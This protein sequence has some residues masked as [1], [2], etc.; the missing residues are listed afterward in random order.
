MDCGALRKNQS[1]SPL[2]LLGASIHKQCH[3]SDAWI[4][5][6]LYCQLSVGAEVWRGKLFPLI[7]LGAGIQELQ[8]QLYYIA[9][10]LPHH[11]W[12]VNWD[13]GL[14]FGTEWIKHWIWKWPTPSLGFSPLGAQLWTN[15]PL[16]V[17]GM[18][19]GVILHHLKAPWDRY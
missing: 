4:E 16:L 10:T 19:Q 11:W 15:C 17:T 18:Y 7:C 8:L 2:V 3:S 6:V 13:S 1:T 5:A 14:I 12:W 9:R